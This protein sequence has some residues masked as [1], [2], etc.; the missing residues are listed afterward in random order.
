MI[1]NILNPSHFNLF[2]MDGF[3]IL[4][5][6]MG[7]LYEIDDIAYSLL[8]ESSPACIDPEKKIEAHRQL[9]EIKRLEGEKEHCELPGDRKPRALCLNLT[10]DCNMKCIYCFTKERGKSEESKMAV[11]TAINAIDFLFDNSFSSSP[12]QI[13]FF[14]GEPLLNFEVLKETV[15][16]AKDKA[17]NEE[18]RIKFTLTTN[19]VLLDKKTGEF[20]NREGFSTILSIDGPPELHNNQ[21]SFKNSSAS[22][23]SIVFKNIKNF[24]INRNY[25]NYYIR[26]TYTPSSLNIADT[27]RYFKEEGFSNF[28]LEPARGKKNEP[29][30]VT[31]S[32]LPLLFNEYENLARYSLCCHNKNEPFNFFHFNINPDTPLC[33]T[34]RLTG[35]GAGVEYLSIDPDGSIYPCHH[36]HDEKIFHMGSVNDIQKSRQFD[37]IN[38]M[39]SESHMFNKAHCKNCW[40]RYYCSGGCHAFS[41]FESGDILKQDKLGCA[42][43]K[44]RLECALWLFAKINCRKERFFSFV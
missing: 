34:R 10:F 9:L 38:K 15:R 37:E 3:H 7:G 17:L 32:D 5:G 23:C 31:E 42:L 19:G 14:G 33:I 16:Y 35:C 39:F 28:S 36:L 12:L 41:Y 20:V 22:R 43:Q 25:E 40:A 6:Y 26:G 21:R 24:L 1:Q 27:G 4:I 8:A 2:S 11:E 29:W 30:A 18:R 44:K 13:D